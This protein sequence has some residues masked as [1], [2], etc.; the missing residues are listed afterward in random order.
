M[1]QIILIAVLLFTANVA[2][3][4]Q[5]EAQDRHFQ[6][7]EGFKE[8]VDSDPNYHTYWLNCVPEEQPSP[9]AEECHNLCLKK[10]GESLG[11]GYGGYDS[12]YACF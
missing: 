5:T 9:K 12:R 7:A 4:E 10:C 3:A 11:C 2:G 6:C 1:T 8:R